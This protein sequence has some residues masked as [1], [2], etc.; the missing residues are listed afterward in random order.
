VQF[1][2]QAFA[3]KEALLFESPLLV[4]AAASG[5]RKTSVL[6]MMKKARRK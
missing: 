6:T 4:S 2:G 5:K 1:G 3:L